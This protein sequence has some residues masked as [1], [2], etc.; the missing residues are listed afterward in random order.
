MTVLLAKASGRPLALCDVG[1]FDGVGS[2]AVFLRARPDGAV[3]L[4][5]PSEVKKRWVRLVTWDF[6]ADLPCPGKAKVRADHHRTNSPCAEREY[7]D[8][9]AP[10]AAILAV[11]AMGLEGDPIAESIAAIAVETDTANIRTEEAR[12]LDAAVRAASYGEKLYIANILAREGLNA[13]K[14]DKLM[15]LAQRGLKISEV[16]MDVAS[17]VDV[18]EAVVLYSPRRLPIPYRQLAIELERRGAALVLI[19]VKRGYR[20]YRLYCGARRETNYD[21]TK[22]AVALGGGGHKYAAGAQYKSPFYRPGEGLDRFL[23]VARAAAPPGTPIYVLR[24]DYAVQK[25]GELG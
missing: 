20:T 9:E 6:V 2:A 17:K 25:E 16:V 4:A 10:C 1:D 11:R 15:G 24:D 7:Y 19:L 18:S 21:C 5:A 12:L 14:D 13:L 3:V 8:A 22:V 23:S